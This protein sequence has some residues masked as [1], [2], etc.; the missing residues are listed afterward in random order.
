[1]GAERNRNELDHDPVS[2]LAGTILDLLPVPDGETRERLLDVANPY[3]PELLRIVRKSDPED[4]R[5][6][7]RRHF[8]GTNGQ[9]IHPVHARDLIDRALDDQ[10]RDTFTATH[11]HTIQALEALRDEL[12]RAGEPEPD[13]PEDDPMAW[14]RADDDDTDHEPRD[15]V[16]DGNVPYPTRADHI[17]PDEYAAFQAWQAS[18]TNNDDPEVKS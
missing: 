11:D 5:K 16:D 6:G 7:I 14:A 9:Y 10:D 4:E 1:M 15:G 13:V 18:Q 17:D 2:L 12:D 8:K 3:R